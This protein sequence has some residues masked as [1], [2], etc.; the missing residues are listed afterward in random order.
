[1]STHALPPS[2][3]NT[4]LAF[5]YKSDP[6]L[7]KARFLF[8]VMSN[9]MLVQLGTRLTPWSIRMGLP[10]KG[11]IRSTI[12][13]QFIGGETLE[14]T[15]PVAAKLGSFQVKVILDYGVEG[16]QG[17]HFYDQA[18]DE[19]VRVIDF[20]A[21]QPNIPFISIKLTGLARFELLEELHRKM[22]VINKPLLERYELALN[23]L[24]PALLNEWG[25]VCSRMEKICFHATA[26][27]IAVA[28]DAEETWIQEP[29]DA[30]CAIMMELCNKKSPFVYNT[31][32]L[33]RT[34]RLEFLQAMQQL[35]SSR[36]YI[37]GAK[38]VRGA[39]MEKERKRATQLGYTS[40]INPNKEATDKLYN[41]AL[42][43]CIQHIN[44]F[45]IVVASHNEQSCLLA[46]NLLIEQGLPSNHPHIH[47][48][49]LYGMSDNITFNLAAA[50]CSVSKY[51]PFGPIEDVVPYLM[52]RAQENT[53][54]KGQTGRELGLIQKELVR[55]A[56]SA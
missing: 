53:S 19:F 17:E 15:I 51:L 7:K 40:P 30:L 38:L 25:R 22:V 55:R 10:V 13:S 23:Q 12:F 43:F 29:L 47:W 50:G 16:K 48:S 39:Y 54:V 41:S 2:F 35:A 34:D 49:Q 33:Y 9:P 28:L 37:S 4:A 27:K 45:G 26:K 44:H 24:S 21:T 32:Q 18:R 14:Q 6:E 36:G 46:F 5:Q 52:R 20:A 31:Y 1:M 3:D 8:K 56:H 11:L 42:R